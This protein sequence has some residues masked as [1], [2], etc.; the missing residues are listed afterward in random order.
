M[1]EKF[2]NQKKKKDKLGFWTSTSLVV[3]NMIGSGIFLLPSALAFYGGISI[4]GWI[5]TSIGAI[6]LALLFVDLS[7]RIP[8]L[9]GPYAYV[10]HSFG[11]F[12]G[13]IV[14]WGYWVSIIC[15]NAAISIALVSYLSIF[16][17]V[18]ASNNLLAALTAISMIWILTAINL[19]GI[20]ESG[21][22]QFITTL[23]KLVPLVAVAI[24]GIFFFD[25]NNFTPFNVS[26]ENSF[27]AVTATAALTL[28]AFLGLE[29][30]T[31]PASSIKDP[32]KTIP[33]STI[34]GTVVTALV[35]IFGTVAIMGVLPNEFLVTSN[36]PYSDAATKMWGGGAGLFVAA[37]GV[38]SCFGAL[39][40]WILLQG[41]MPLAAA[42][43]GLLP[44]KFAEISRYGTPWF[45]IIIASLFCTLLIIMNYTKG[46]VEQFTQIIL[47]A[48][49]A[50]L[51]PYLLSSLAELKILLY[52]SRKSNRE[53]GKL[54]LITVLAFIYSVWATV[55]IGIEMIGWG[56]VFIS[57][58]IP[59]YLWKKHTTKKLIKY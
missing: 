24:F 41:Q 37:G 28:W 49:L 57:T 51:L 19:L 38:I 6:T 29:S 47:I 42:L 3:G 54:L 7:K 45:G 16:F 15:G 36:A 48:T 40:G 22:V 12:P 27:D 46:L 21:K 59:I 55:G 8:K 35:Y 53:I 31:I 14:A 34:A 39:N 33:R 1:S 13:F 2:T 10:K 20:R 56:I 43:D 25:I 52:E 50:T 58:G 30:A 18:I 9:G 32:E 11:N 17:P 44:K 23:L 4:V 5:F 26:N